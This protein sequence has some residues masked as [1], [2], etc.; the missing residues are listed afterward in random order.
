MSTIT[1]ELTVDQ[2]FDALRKLPDEDRALLLQKLGEMELV[3]PAQTVS[4]LPGF[5]I[6]KDRAD[7]TDSA[8]S[9]SKLR[10]ETGQR[11]NERQT[12]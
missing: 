5:G 1:I 11:Q 2:L 3:E 9:A 6:W 8:E 10:R 4:E 7:I 12:H